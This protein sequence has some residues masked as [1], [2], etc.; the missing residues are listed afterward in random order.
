MLAGVLAAVTF[1]VV[2]LA[3]DP[4]TLLILKVV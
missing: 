3:A 2:S 1:P 4:V